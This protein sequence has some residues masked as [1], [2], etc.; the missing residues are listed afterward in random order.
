L[1]VQKQAQQKSAYI[2]DPNAR[3]LVRNIGGNLGASKEQAVRLKEETQN[4][5]R[6]L[7]ELGAQPFVVH[8]DAPWLKLW[9]FLQAMVIAYLF[10][11][12]PTANARVS[13]CSI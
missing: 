3:S 13:Q 2:A 9:D 5:Q 8:P 6:Q 11:G 7:K 4:A 12:A 10:V 1:Q